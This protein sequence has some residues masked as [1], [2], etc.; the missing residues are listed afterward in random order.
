[1]ATHA[2][3]MTKAVH[4]VCISGTKPGLINYPSRGPVEFPAGQAGPGCFQDSFLGISDSLPDSPLL[5]GWRTENNGPA[6]I[7]DIVFHRAAAI[8]KN[9]VTGSKYLGSYNPVRRGC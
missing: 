6:D 2:D 5:C 9:N 1:M 3:A 4:K 7:A 8:D